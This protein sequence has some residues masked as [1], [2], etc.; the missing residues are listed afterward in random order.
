M[1]HWR[2][3]TLLFGLWAIGSLLTTSGAFGQTKPIDLFYSNVYPAPHKMCVSAVEWGKEI[4]KRTN[5]RVK[6]T[7]YPGGTLTPGDKCYDGVVKGLSH[8]GMSVFS[9]TVG[10]FPLL[11]VI[12]LPLGVKS[13]SVATRVTNELFAKF[14]PKELDEVKV[15]FLMGIAPAKVHTKKPVNKLEDLK[16]LKIRATG[17]V[18]RIVAALGA[19]PVAMPM[20]DTYDALSRGVVEGVVCPI[21]AL[22]GWRLGEVVNFTAQNTSTSNSTAQFVVMNKDTW[23]SLSPDIQNIIEKVNEEY[24]PKMGALWDE[25]DKSALDFVIKKGNKVISLPAEEQ[26]RWAKAVRPLLDDY[27]NRMKAKGL[28][29]D[30]ALKFC[31]ERLKALQ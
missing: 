2:W 18:S 3:A 16:G 7:M 15:M 6:V 13:G 1:K 23:N 29:G 28:P 22:E 12:D 31:L 10:K 11:E 24:I 19:T 5:G 17:T 4:E 14:K 20:P 26:E 27:V 21:E 25:L 30:E 9:Y 8:V